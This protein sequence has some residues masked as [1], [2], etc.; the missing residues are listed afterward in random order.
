VT[1][2]ARLRYFAIERTPGA[3]PELDGLRALAI[4][5]VLARHATLAFPSP[6]RIFPVGSSW[7]AATPLRNG[8]MGVDL[9]FV[10]SGFL[11]T[12]HLLRRRPAHPTDETIGRYLT[13][14]ALRI[15]P[16]YYAVLLVVIW[17]PLP[18]YVFS[19]DDLGYRLVYHLA[20]LQDYLPSDF[21]VAFWSLGVEEK[22]Y[23]L[24]PF[25]IVP[26][27]HTRRL[28]TPL[29]VLTV[30][31]AAPA[32]GRTVAYARAE[33]WTYPA[34]FYAMRS[35][36]H[37]SA[38]GLW[39]G[40]ACA[41]VFTSWEHMGARP[42]GRALRIAGTAV[43]GAALL[44]T[45]LL[46]DIGRFVATMLGTVLALGFGACLLGCWRIRGRRCAACW[47]P[48]RCFCSRGCPTAFT[49]CTWCS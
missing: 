43:I 41:F 21:V 34:Y 36:F 44:V 18:H 47:A 31:A 24:A 32:V 4:L 10:L 2:A 7:D 42:P 6:E 38:D 13:R 16:A 26:L 45:P 14:R 23:L 40:A 37:M 25:V 39:V 49:W 35:P 17:M 8:W 30:L 15:V 20:F 33:S 27:L 11:I 5:L 46:D 1:L 48:G 9:F 12:L 29:L 28:A 22:F 3:I 19:R